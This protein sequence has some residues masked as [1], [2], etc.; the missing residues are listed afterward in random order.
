MPVGEP[1]ILRRLP[2]WSALVGAVLFYCLSFTPSLL[3]RPGLLQAA[4]GAITAFF[5]YGLGAFF[6]MVARRCGLLPSPAVRRAGWWLLAVVGGGSVVAI[7]AWSVRWQGDLRRAVG[8]D[9]RIGW[10]QWALVLPVALL[11]G[12]LLVLAARGVRLGTRTLREVLGRA[13]PG[14][15]AAAGAAA[16]AVVLVTGFAQGFLLRA[17]LGAAERGAALTDRSTSPGTVR[18]PWAAGGPSTRTAAPCA[19][20]SRPPT[21]R[22]PA[23]PGRSPG[24]ATCRT[25]ATP[26]CGGSPP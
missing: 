10:W 13:V 15:A 9:P 4:A 1:R 2:S 22:C 11:L 18:Q 21:S 23:R 14:W 25:A 6:G 19:S 5:G 8:L 20:P 24:W 12:A 7:T 17:L 16:L 3:P 26:W